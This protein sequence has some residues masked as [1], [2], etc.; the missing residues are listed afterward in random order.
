[1]KPDAL[2]QRLLSLSP[3]TMV[4]IVDLTGTQDHYQASIV[5]DAFAGLS[6]LEQ[7]RMVYALVQPEVSSGEL[8]ALSLKTQSP[9]INPTGQVHALADHAREEAV[10]GPEDHSA[11]RGDLRARNDDS[12]S[13]TGTM[14]LEDPDPHQGT[15][16]KDRPHLS[17]VLAQGQ[18]PE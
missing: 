11:T 6:M 9:R 1:M 12:G 17:R 18:L 4:E 16:E 2:R 10:I 8:H 5:S 13:K 3:S 7:H 15:L 14:P